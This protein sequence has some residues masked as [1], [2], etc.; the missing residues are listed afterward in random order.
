VV[1]RGL[2][3]L[4]RSGRWGAVE[5]NCEWEDEEEKVVLGQAIANSW[6]KRRHYDTVERKGAIQAPY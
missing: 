4:L 5:R 1:E 3:E 6:R 2:G